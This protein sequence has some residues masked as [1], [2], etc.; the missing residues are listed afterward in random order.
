[1]SVEQADRPVKSGS[2]LSIL[3]GES[4]SG[5]LRATNGTR[6]GHRAVKGVG[7]AVPPLIL[8]GALIA[9]WEIYVQVKNVRPTFLPAPSRVVS[10]GWRW[11]DAIWV[12][13]KVTLK[14]TAFGF[15]VSVVIATAFAVAMDFSAT[16][17]RALYPLLVASQTLPIVVLAPLMITWFGFGLKPKIIL[18]VL[19]TFFPVT[20]GWV[21]GF[22]ST[23]G[24]AMNLLRSMG[25]GRWR[26]FRYVRFPSALPSFFSGL[27]IAITYAVIGAVFA[28][29]AGA[30]QGLGIYMQ[31]QK[32]AFRID[33][34]MAAVFVTALVSVALFSLT[35]VIQRLAI[36]WHTATRKHAAG[37]RDLR[38]LD[39]AV[40]APRAWLAAWAIR[41]QN[42]RKDDPK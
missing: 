34:V 13:T 23:E 18:V 25:A 5:G 8:L 20:V 36:P 42:A 7:R 6:F 39:L 1:V 37:G 29:Y 28:E 2:T 40:V 17:R 22:R 9:T 32:N 38:G 14:E 12:N 27:R 26:V 21:D 35:S 15:S 16:V 10:E 11:K 24:D 3:P 4:T 33:L 19:I 30:K 31:L 41:N